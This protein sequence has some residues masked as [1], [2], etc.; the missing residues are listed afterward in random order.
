[1]KHIVI[2]HLGPLKEADIYLKSINVIIGSQLS[3]HMQ[4]DILGQAV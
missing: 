1:M 3:R 2:R 4:S